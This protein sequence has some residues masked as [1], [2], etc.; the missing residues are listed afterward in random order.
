MRVED[1]TAIVQGCLTGAW[2]AKVAGPGRAPYW[3]LTAPDGQVRSLMGLHR[4]TEAQIRA[5]VKGL[6]TRMHYGGK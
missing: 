6:V 1:A 3:L 4:M 5:R 2:S